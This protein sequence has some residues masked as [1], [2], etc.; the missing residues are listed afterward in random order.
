MAATTCGQRPRAGP[1]RRQRVRVPPTPHVPE[2]L[3]TDVFRGSQ[4]V[5]AGLLTH[6]QLRGDT[7]R[8]LFHDVYVHRDVPITHELRSRGAVLL[9]PSAVVTGVSAA[10]LWGVGLAGPTDDVELTLPPH[11][12]MIRVRGLCTRRAALRRDDTCRRRGLRVSTPEATA[13]RLGGA[14]DLDAAVAAIDRLIRTGIVDLDSIRGRAAMAYGPGSARARRAADLADGLAESPQETR[15][16]LLLHRSSLPVPVA[17]FRIV[18]R[19]TFVARVDFAWPE[20]K[21]ALEYDGMWHAE[22]GQFFRDRTRLNRLQA[23]GWRVVFVTA[24]D[25]YRPA[26]LIARIAA[27]LGIAH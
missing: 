19:A 2:E 13:V 21:V 12:H 16:R 4:V 23:A 6:R 1:R 8:R 14:L 27:A 26:E 5:H 22:A 20:H 17:Q 18:D 7:W 3:R 25:L 24:A 11:S 9:C 10:V 15:L